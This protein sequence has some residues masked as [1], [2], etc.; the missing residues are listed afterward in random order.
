MTSVRFRQLRRRITELR[1]HLLPRSLDPTG[2]YSDRVYERTRAFRVL[3]HAEFEAYIEDR[4]LE[5]LADR[6]RNWTVNGQI[7][8]C[9]VSL[10][11]YV[12]SPLQPDV[13]P[14]LVPPQKPAPLLDERVKHAWQSHQNYVRMRNHGV[15]EHNLLRLLIPIGLDPSQFDLVW[16]KSL[17][18]WA[19]T[20]GLYAHQSKIKIQTLPD[21]AGEIRMARELLEG[22]KML[23]AALNSV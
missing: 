3:V 20:R 14:L 7:S 11:A 2:S 10:V 12:D 6:F 15:K 1:L 18:S 17:D 8:R 9:L 21:P 16:L 19:T 4:T 22:F 5:V 23:D 13:S